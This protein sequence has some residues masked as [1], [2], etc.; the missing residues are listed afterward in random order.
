MPYAIN[1]NLFAI[2]ALITA[3]T[4]FWL[5]FLAFTYAKIKLHR[6]WGVF[7]LVIGGWAFFVFLAAIS[8]NSST[9]YNFWCISHVIGIFVS[10]LI[11]HAACLFCNL[12]YPNLIRLSYLYG[13][14]HIFLNFWHGGGTLYESVKTKYLFDSIYYLQAK[15]FFAVWLSPWIFL[16]I[17]TIFHLFKYARKHS[18]HSAQ[19]WGIVSIIGYLGGSSTFL[20][21]FGINIYPV[22]LFLLPIYTIILTYAIFRYQFIDLQVILEK[23]IVYSL[24]VAITSAV[25]LIVVMGL[26]RSVQQI[27]HYQSSF[28]SIATALGIG[29]IITPLS[30]KVRFWADRLIFKATPLEI[31]QQNE[32]YR[33]EATKSEKFKTVATLASGIAHEIKNPITTIKTFFDHIPD[34]KDDPEFLEKLKRIAGHEITRVNDLVQELLEFAKPSPAVFKETP[35]LKLLNETLSFISPQLHKNNVHLIKQ[36]DQTSDVA[37]QIDSN[38]IKQALLN[39]LLN[40]ID[41]MPNGGTLTLSTQLRSA[42]P[43]SVSICIRDTGCGIDKKDLPHIFDPF[44]SKKANGTGLG[45]AISKGIIEEHNG[46]IKVKSELE[47]GTTQFQIELP[48]I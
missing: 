41:A 8:K 12:H 44:F 17:F 13:A 9:A 2:S 10:V 7:N 38:K 31:A 34:K 21:M 46:K 5:S 33:L 19:L 37:L 48:L 40:A 1:L 32:L 24:V 18:S 3:L 39:I 29:M 47:K 11:F 43:Q 16:A 42:S 35:I 14:T 22:A 25:Y 28:I 15:P 30:S 23:S 27:F 45:L 4:C 6:I 20:P 36:L 26:E